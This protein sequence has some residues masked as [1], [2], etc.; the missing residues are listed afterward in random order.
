MNNVIKYLL[1]L[2]SIVLIISCSEDDSK[3]DSTG[4]LA[5]SLSD[6]SFP[7]DLVDQANVQINK[8]EIRRKG[9]SD[10]GPYVV[11]SE[12]SVS[13]NLLDLSNGVTATLADLEIEAGSFDQIR[14]YVEEANVIL[15]DGTEFELN[16][17]S[18]ASSGIKI[19]IDPDV[20]V[21]GGETTSLLLDFDVNRSFVVQGNPDTP[22]GI[23]GFNF[24]PTIRAVNLGYSGTLS[25]KITDDQGNGISGTTIS[26]SQNG[27]NI[28]SALSDEDGNYTVLGLAAGSYDISIEKDGYQ[29]QQIENIQISSGETTTQDVTLNM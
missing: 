12:E 23:K 20:E 16:V 29:S 8:I 27:V 6:A 13:F 10:N 2:L 22:A 7:S 19:F 17:P 18:G 15:T 14:L 4:R 25:G 5:I 3:D 28:T 11:L 21:E 24:T 9:N 26:T 1:I